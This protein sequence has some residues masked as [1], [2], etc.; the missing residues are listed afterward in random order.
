V[1]GPAQ[2]IPEL[3][4]FSDEPGEGTLSEEDAGAFSAPRHHVTTCIQCRSPLDAEL[5]VCP[6]CGALQPPPNP[7]VLAR[8]T[9]IDLGHARVVVD[10]RIG[11]GG[12]GIVYR[13]WLFHAPGDARAEAPEIVALKQLRPQAQTNPAAR[14]QFLNEAR[15]LKHLS[16]PNVTR[17]VELFEYGPSL[18]LALEYIEGATLEAVLARQVARARL[19][20]AGALP[21]MPFKRAW[22]YFEQLLGALAAIH[23]LGIVHRDIKPSNILIRHDGIVKLTDFGIVRFG[24]TQPIAAVSESMMSQLAPGTG[25]YM[26]PEQVLSKAL[27]GRSDLYSAAIVLYEMLSGRTPFLNDRTEF[28]VR[29]DQVETPPPSIR[30]WLPQAP[31]VLDSLFARALAKDPATRFTSAIEL[32]NAFRVALGLPE[33]A[34]WR[35]QADFARDAHPPSGDA[36]APVVSEVRHRLATLR[37]FMEKGY[38]ATSA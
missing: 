28:L 2:G 1:G 16:H 37:E 24:D 15:A 26:S 34:E 17:F 30:A 12:M 7:Y 6:A 32:G 25:A 4:F 20:G 29:R 22:H 14:P 10:A 5:R 38:K 11:E 36:Q 19:A 33:T 31:P 13:G 9:T 23:A 27:D 3:K 18:V 35:A 8:G 21:G